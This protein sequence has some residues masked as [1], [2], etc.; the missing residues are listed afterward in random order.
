MSRG[1]AAPDGSPTWMLHD[2][3][4][5]HFYQLGW[6]AFEIL[7]RWSLDDR[8]KIVEAVNRDT[9]LTVSLDDFDALVR[10]LQGA[11]LFVAAT[12]DSTERLRA[13]AEARRVTR[14]MWLLKHYLLIRIPL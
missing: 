12:A 2:P 14:A 9:T 8:Q 6:P 10:L 3:A 11:N 5:N 13:V 4:A 7:S 1:A